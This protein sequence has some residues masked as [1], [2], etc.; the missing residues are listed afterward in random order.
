MGVEQKMKAQCG[1]VEVG[2]LSGMLEQVETT[3]MIHLQGWWEREAQGGGGKAR[4]TDT[5]VAGAD[6]GEGNAGPDIST[7]GRVGAVPFD[8]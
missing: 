7:H 6:E 3:S 8:G 5:K 2:G 4:A 1:N